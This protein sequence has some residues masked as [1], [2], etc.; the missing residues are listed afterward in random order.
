MLNFVCVFLRGYI[1]YK[2]RDIVLPAPQLTDV[3]VTRSHEDDPNRMVEAASSPARRSLE[4]RPLIFAFYDGTVG[5]VCPD[6]QDDVWALNIKR[7]VLTAFQNSMQVL[8]R[9]EQI[10]E[11]SMRDNVGDLQT[12]VKPFA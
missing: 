1:L 12:Q 8:D 3:K 11:V 5:E 2:H 10:E 6:E 4:K 9:D 7:G